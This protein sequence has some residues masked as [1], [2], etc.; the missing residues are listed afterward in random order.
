MTRGRHDNTALV[1][2]GNH[3][4]ESAADLL[5]QV[6]ASDRADTPAIDQRR[7]LA[8]QIPPTARTPRRRPRCTIPDWWH[9]LRSDNQHELAD[10][11]GKLDAMRANQ[12][13]R[14]ERLTALH[15][16][17]ETAVAALNP[18]REQYATASQ[19]VDQAESAHTS[20]EAHLN[21]VGIRGR[22]VARSQ[23]ASAVAELDDA[24]SEFAPIEAIWKPLL[25]T[26]DR[27]ARAYN[28]AGES[29]RL[30]TTLE[31]IHQLPERL[32]TLQDFANALDTWRQWAIGAK[33]TT[34]AATAAV[35]ILGNV[36][37]HQFRARADA[38]TTISPELIA[39]L[40]TPER[41]RGYAREEIDFGI[42]T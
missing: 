36:D 1:D 21:T 40:G 26:A 28:D 9:E 13:A 34:K 35:G 25:Q 18:Y 39:E 22:R 38:L 4:I 17:A 27:A 5:Q 19:R 31:D 15:D 3:T 12:L 14:V 41:G 33:I 20:A 11:S 29:C 6:L 23:V 16:L 10:V 8:Q 2:T 37:D 30:Q 24:R 42:D 7:E 32:E